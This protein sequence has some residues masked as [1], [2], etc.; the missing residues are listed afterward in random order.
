MLLAWNASTSIVKQNNCK[1]KTTWLIQ[2]A[3]SKYLIDTIYIEIV[4]KFSKN[5]ELKIVNDP[6]IG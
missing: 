2:T 1:N 3:L 4:F 5:V 6:K